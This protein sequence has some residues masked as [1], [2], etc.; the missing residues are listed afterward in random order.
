MT[1]LKQKRRFTESITQFYAA[2]VLLALEELHLMM[3]AYRD[4]KVSIKN[5]ALNF[6]FCFQ[7]RKPFLSYS[8]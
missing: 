6:Y 4:L 2:S 8:A 5:G 7:F 3:I 1:Y